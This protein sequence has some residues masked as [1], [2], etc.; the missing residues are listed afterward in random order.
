[1]LTKANSDKW[2]PDY[3]FWYGWSAMQRDLAE[4][5]M[6]AEEMRRNPKH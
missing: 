2:K 1:M 4:I 6:L 3:A 5:R